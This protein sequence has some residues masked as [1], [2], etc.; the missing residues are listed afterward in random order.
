MP[1]LDLDNL[2]Y[3]E[4]DGTIIFLD[5]AADR[6]FCLSEDR[7]RDVMA[8]IDHSSSGSW[9]QPARF[10][11]PSQWIPPKRACPAMHSGPFH[12]GEVARALWMQRRIERRLAS[13]SL[14]KVLGDLRDITVARAYSRPITDIAATRVIRAFE[15]AR[16]LRT[17]ADR[18][19]PRSIALALCLAARGVR[20]RVV[21]GV[22]LAQFGAH[23]WAQAGDEVL[24]DSAE[25]A[26]RHSPI[27]MI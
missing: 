13:T 23:C 1:S 3:C 18:C 17:A 12:M 25:E 20:V 14:A 7:N 24:N 5:V 2:A 15:Q 21:I 6:Y 8:K 19:L 9:H 10:P 11:R 16:L 27:L 4:I 26:M 22:K